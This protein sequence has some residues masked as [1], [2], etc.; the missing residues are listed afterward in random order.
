MILIVVQCKEFFKKKGKKKEFQS[1][2]STYV[3]QCKDGC[4]N[5]LSQYI[6]LDIVKKFMK[7]ITL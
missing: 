3:V 7:F 5:H 2:T 6:I 4:N 1:I